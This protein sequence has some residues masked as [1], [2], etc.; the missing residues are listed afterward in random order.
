MPQAFVRLRFELDKVVD[1][2]GEGL[3][4]VALAIA[5][6]EYPRLDGRRVHALLDEVGERVAGF[7]NGVGDNR[8]RMSRFCAE[9]YGQLGFRGS[10]DYDD[11]RNNYLNDVLERRTGSP[12][13][14]AVVLQALGRR[15]GVEV[16]P[17][18][19]PGH[20]LVRAGPAPYVYADPYDGRHPLPRAKLEQLAIRELRCG[21]S[22]A[23]ARLEP[24]DS[25]AVAVR[26]LLNLQRIHRMRAD[27]PRSLVISDRLFAL[28]G[29]PF[30][31]CDRALHALV[32]GATVAAVADLEAYLVEHPGAPDAGRV[33]R[34]L[35][36]LR[37]RKPTLV[38]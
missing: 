21:A 14:M 32:L 27:H 10:D 8:L 3:E 25:R 38:H 33:R 29:A 19:F 36:R 6:D 13:L 34:V 17:I 1:E 26:I 4:E 9:L 20:F 35:E 15:A 31:R 22:E 7:L 5:S 16:E 12:V 30:Y 24:V 2:P 28:T 18:A 37:S 23:S 11:P